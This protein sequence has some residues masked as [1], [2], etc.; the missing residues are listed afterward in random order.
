MQPRAPDISQYMASTESL[1]SSP[2]LM[3]GRHHLLEGACCI[4]IVDDGS[5][6]ATS[7]IMK[8]YVDRGLALLLRRREAVP[9]VFQGVQWLALNAAL[10]FIPACVTWCACSTSHRSS[11][12]TSLSRFTLRVGHDRVQASRHRP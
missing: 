5:T 3:D 4:V 1:R 7:A 6:D 10:A 9:R 12:V 11:A 2:P 8:G